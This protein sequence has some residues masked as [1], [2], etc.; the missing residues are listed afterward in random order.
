MKCRRTIW[1]EIM[2]RKW[3]SWWEKE[4]DEMEV[5]MDKVEEREEVVGEEEDEMKEVSV[6]KEVDMDAY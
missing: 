6:G 2:C 4:E 1:R 3:R 5:E